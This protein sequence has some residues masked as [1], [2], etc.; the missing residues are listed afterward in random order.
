MFHFV[1]Y[2]MHRC[3]K[4]IPDPPRGGIGPRKGAGQN[5]LLTDGANSVFPF[6]AVGKSIFRELL[7]E[8][9]TLFDCFLKKQRN[10]LAFWCGVWYN[11]YTI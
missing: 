9:A 10:I 1:K 3:E 5:V 6:C 11:G 7:F 4:N 2:E 8:N